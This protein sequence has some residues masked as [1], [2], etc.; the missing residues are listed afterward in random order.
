QGLLARVEHRPGPEGLT[1]VLS[2]TWLK[3][4]DTVGAR[5]SVL[6]DP[7]A[8]SRNLPIGLNRGLGEGNVPTR[9]AATVGYELPFGPGKA[10]AAG[11]PWSKILG[12][13]T[14]FG[15]LAYQRGP[16]V[17]PVMSFD[18]NDVGSTAS[19]RPDVLRNPN[20]SGSERS[21]LRWFDTGAFANP[22]LFAYGNAG[23]SI[24]QAPGI[25]NLDSALLR[26]FRVT[27]G[28]RLEFRW[29]LFN[30]TN[31]TNFSVP[32]TVFGTPQFGVLTSALESRNMQL[33]VKFYF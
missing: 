7:S 23:R 2:Y 22:A 11:G 30:A 31:H 14:L 3:A 5:L 32:G 1:V 25:V 18:R 12:G 28:S 15:L 20:I 8:R 13:W 33:G 9:I 4:I 16:Y 21:P 24:I 27:E 6:G 19:F 26:S 10:M 17:T 29:E